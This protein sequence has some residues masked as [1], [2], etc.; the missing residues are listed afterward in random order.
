MSNLNEIPDQFWS[1]Q[2]VG[3]T[4]HYHNGFGEYVRSVVV[5][6]GDPLDPRKALKPIGLVG[7]WPQYELSNRNTDGEIVRGWFA[8]IIVSADDSAP[9]T[10]RPHPSNIYETDPDDFRSNPTGEELI[11]LSAPD[12][13]PRQRENLASREILALIEQAQDNPALD[14]TDTLARIRE[15][16][17]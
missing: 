12:P 9:H 14:A 5:A 2:K 13:T 16:L 11:D 10:W 4:L 7:N 8:S 3:D 15:I 17:A 6:S 1:R